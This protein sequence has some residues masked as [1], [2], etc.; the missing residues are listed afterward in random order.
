MMSIGTSEILV[1]LVIGLIVLGPERL[2]KVARSVARM[3]R[4]LR[5]Y[6]E[7]VRRDLSKEMILDD[8]SPTRS[9]PMS[10]TEAPD[11]VD[12]AYHYGYDE[13]ENDG[14]DGAEEHAGDGEDADG[15]ES[16][17]PT[18]SDEMPD[19]AQTS[20]DNDS[21]SARSVN[22]DEESTEQENAL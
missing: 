7:D 12:S 9:K 18:G 15:E 20:D 14:E 5:K 21:G 11:D 4:E 13:N 6:A 8:T 17:R 22:S 10:S 1:V 3:Y 16:D 2:P 19:N